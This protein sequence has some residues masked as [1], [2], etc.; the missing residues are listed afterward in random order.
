MLPDLLADQRH[1]FRIERH[2]YRLSRLCLVGMNQANRRTKSTCDHWRPVTFDARKPVASENA[3]V[4]ARCSGKAS[5]KRM[6]LGPSES[7]RAAR[8]RAATVD[9]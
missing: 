8:E 6:P 7:D 9:R 4:S 3:A 1:R 5:K 2:R